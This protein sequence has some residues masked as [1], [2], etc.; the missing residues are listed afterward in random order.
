MVLEAL[1]VC[2]VPNTSTPISAAVMASAMVSMS[3]ISPT[4]ITPG[5]WRMAERSA[6]AKLLRVGAH[7]A[8]AEHGALLVRVHELDRVFDGDDVLGVPGVDADR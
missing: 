3:R 7:L 6:L 8:L 1:L 4:R 2:S 5:S